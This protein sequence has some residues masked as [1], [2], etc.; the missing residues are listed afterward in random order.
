MPKSSTVKAVSN[1]KAVSKP[2]TRDDVR[3]FL[4]MGIAILLLAILA[5]DFVSRLSRGGEK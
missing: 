5:H 3:F 4:D 2:L 1:V